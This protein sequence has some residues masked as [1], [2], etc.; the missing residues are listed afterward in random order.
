MGKSSYQLLYDAWKRAHPNMSGAVLQKEVNLFWNSN[1]KDNIHLVK[2]KIHALSQ[3]AERCPNQMTISSWINKQTGPPKKTQH[4]SL[5]RPFQHSA[6]P[7]EQE[8]IRI[9]QDEDTRPVLGRKSIAQEKLME[10]LNIVNEEIARIDYLRNTRFVTDEDKV[11][12]KLLKKKQTTLRG[13]LKRL[14][15]AAINSRKYRKNKKRKIEELIS[16]H[17]ELADELEAVIQ[18]PGSGRPRLEESQP[19]L[20]KTIVDIVAPESCTDQRRRTELL[21]SCK[22]LEDLQHELER[23]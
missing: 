6:D 11:Q 20:L 12:L 14:K 9:D 23:K 21:N 8:L 1:K 5:T 16:K 10:D 19:M 3:K 22:T 7:L 17:P 15:N 4:I 13:H 18:S 2:E